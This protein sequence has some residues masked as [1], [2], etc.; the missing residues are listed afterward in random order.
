MGKDRTTFLG[1]VADGD[2]DIE[3]LVLEFFNAFR[4]VVE[5]VNAHFFHHFNCQWIDANRVGSCARHVKPI[6][7]QVTKPSFGHL[8]PTGVARAEEE[9]GSF[10]NGLS[11]GN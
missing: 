8:A 6:S 11:S 1:L 7:C 5:N 9:H 10:H 3:P 4:V 2:H